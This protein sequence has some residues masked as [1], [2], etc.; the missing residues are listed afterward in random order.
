MLRPFRLE[1]E[2]DRAVGQWLDWLP[3]WEPLTSRPRRS[4]WSSR[5]SAS[6]APSVT[7]AAI[8]RP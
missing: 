7:W 6:S 2:L 5:A 4:A 3:R 1:R 8:S